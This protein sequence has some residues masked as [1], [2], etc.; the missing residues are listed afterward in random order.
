MPEA[1]QEPCLAKQDRVRIPRPKID[2]LARQAQ[3]VGIHAQRV[4]LAT[5]NTTL[6]VDDIQPRGLMIYRNKLRID[7]QGFALI[8]LRKCAIIEQIN[9]KFERCLN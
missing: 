5:C 8:Y 1:R 6:R 3:G 4:S 9:K 7:I 2:E